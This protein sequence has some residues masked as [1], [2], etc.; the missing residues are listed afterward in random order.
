MPVFCIGGIKLENLPGVLAAGAERVV[1]VS[2]LLLA[3]D[4]A[5]YARACAAQLRG[6]GFSG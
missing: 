2:G 3:A 4:P 1:I 5:G 6:M